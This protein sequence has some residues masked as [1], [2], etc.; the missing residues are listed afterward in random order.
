[1]DF[2]ARKKYTV[3]ADKSL[4]RPGRKQA[5]ATKLEIYS[6]HSAQRSIHFLSLCSNFYKLLNKDSEFCSSNQVPAKAMTSASEEKWLPFNCI[7]VQGTGGSA[8]GPD[9]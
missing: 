3:G 5:T 7:L 9:S 8:T 1:M 4:A 2:L 6:S